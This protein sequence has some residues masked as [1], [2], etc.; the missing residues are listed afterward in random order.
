MGKAVNYIDELMSLTERYGYIDA[1]NI[2]FEA[3][4]GLCRK[5]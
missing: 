1:G 3:Y 4:L 2:H 5:I